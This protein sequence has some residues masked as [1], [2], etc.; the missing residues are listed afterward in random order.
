MSTIRNLILL[1]A[2]GGA[3][4]ASAAA[5]QTHF[6]TIDSLADTMPAGMAEADRMLYGATY[7][8]SFTGSNCGMIFE[9]RPPPTGSTSW[10]QTTLY[11]F[12]PTG[13]DACSPIS[14]PLAAAGGTLY[15]I[16]AG[17]G[18]YG[19]GAFYELQ[20]PAAPGGAWTESVLYSFDLQG[21]G[22]GDPAALAPG[23]NGSFYCGA[24][25]GTDGAGVLV[26]LQPPSSPGGAWTQTVL[27]NFTPGLSP[28][29][30]LPGP[31]GVLYG[32]NMAG[33]IIQ[34][35]PP[36][37]PGGS[38]TETVL[39][40]VT[41]RDGLSP[42]SLVLA[43]DGTLYGTTLGSNYYNGL[44]KAT[45]FQLTPPASS[46]GSWTFT[47]L[48]NFGQQL[49]LLSP[50]I[51]RNGNLYGTATPYGI[52]PFAT[53]GQIFELQR[54]ATAGGA[55]TLVHLHQFTGTQLP[56]GALAMDKNGDI[57]GVTNA[58]YNMPPSGT[59]YRLATK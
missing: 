20:P 50:L 38:W 47:L 30:L 25:G 1:S 35:T 7:L 29:A 43:A 57:F 26:Q 58:P 41:G 51:L 23:P 40:T 21:G 19:W 33:P 42:Y 31:G 17:G 18:A 36:S 11:S 27:Y 54:P 49:N 28:G 16:A 10:T 34:M 9:L 5:A 4:L 44:G 2:C 15:G 3:L 22:T 32:T 8:S 39:Y 14:P 24:S 55:W 59:V 46:G 48:H 37:A 6:T 45:V 56:G 13:G 53:G 52:P 12:A